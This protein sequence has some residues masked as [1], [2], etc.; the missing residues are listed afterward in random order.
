MTPDLRFYAICGTQRVGST[1]L[2]E[3]LATTGRSG[4]PREPFFEASERACAPGLG[5]P[6]DVPDYRD[7]VRATIAQDSTANVFGFKIMWNH[8]RR[9]LDRLAELVGDPVPEHRLSSAFPGLRAVHV[10]RTDKVS[11]AI[12][13]WR[14]EMTGEWSLPSDG[15][16]TAPDRELDIVRVRQLHALA[17][18][19]EQGWPSVLHQAGVPYRT[20]A[21]EELAADSLDTARAVARF[22]D[23]PTQGMQLPDMRIQRDDRTEHWR[24]Q[25]WRLESCPSC[26]PPARSREE[27]R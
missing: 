16:P 14:A 2:C 20:I 19:A 9:F 21:Y 3:T 25:W 11:L 10:T 15:Q 13:Q 6:E 27:K 8:H 5:L 12:S 17:H 24:R 4:T 23:I 26:P 7:Y 18:Q 1:L 22:L